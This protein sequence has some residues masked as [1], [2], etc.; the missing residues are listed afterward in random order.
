M[1]VNYVLNGEGHGPIGSVMNEA[2]VGRRFEADL[3]RPFIDERGRPSVTLNTGRPLK[4]DGKVV[5]NA[6]TGL[7]E[8]E[9]KDFLIR[10]LEKMGVSSPVFNAAFLRKD[11][12]I[13]L[14]TAVVRATRQ[15]LRAWADLAS[16]NSYG[17]FDGMGKMTLEYEMS[18]DPGEAIKDMEAIS[19]GRHDEMLFKLASI[20]L[21]ITHSSFWYS[22]RR[23]A[24]SANS[25][26]PVQTVSAEAAGRRVGEMI[27]RTLIGTETGITFGTRS[28]GVQPHEG[29]STEYGYTNFPYRITKTDLTTPTGLNPDDVFT[30]VLEMRET[31]YS[32]GFYGPFV[33]YTSTGYDLYLDRF[34]TVGTSAQG[35]AAPSTTLR[36]TIE[37][38]EGISAVR[39]LD[40]LTSG[41]QMIMV[42]MTSD[43]AQAV[44][45]MDVTTVQWPEMGGLKQKFRVMAIQTPLLRRN[46][47]GVTGI[48]HGTTS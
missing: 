3:L 30:D 10:D 24:V 46:Y 7:P 14:D 18:S 45:G 9:R 21:P 48:I 1:F 8:P 23:M 35:L 36:R 29:T 32:Y 11:D 5:L 12:W 47:A 44:N 17:G 42:Q 26:M 6:R 22:Q 39:R 34:F 15:R 43:V 38:I 40:F 37:G 33:V 20:P 28:T 13:R 41:Y 4:R 2:R 16:A 19:E 25:G 31:M 27:E